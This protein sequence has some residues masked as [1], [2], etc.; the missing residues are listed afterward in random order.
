M[1]TRNIEITRAPQGLT[2]GFT[3]AYGKEVGKPYTLP[4]GDVISVPVCPAEGKTGTKGFTFIGGPR[5]AWLEALAGE[6]ELSD[7]VQAALDAVLELSGC[8]AGELAEQLK[9]E[10]VW[11]VSLRDFLKF[12]AALAALG[13]G[14]QKYE[15]TIDAKALQSWARLAAVDKDAAWERAPKGRVMVHVD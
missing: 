2:V 3:K 8:T 12:D 6:A 1:F 15:T 4:S 11:E 9:G 5:A 7:E 13:E 14:S 10:F